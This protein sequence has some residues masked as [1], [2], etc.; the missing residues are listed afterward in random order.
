MS[1]NNEKLLNQSAFAKACGVVPSTIRNRVNRGVL[2]PA[3]S[4]SGK[5]YFTEEQVMATRLAILRESITQSFMGL[6]VVNDDA[7]YKKLEEDFV[8]KVKAV[9]PSVHSI[10]SL[11]ESMKAMGA[12]AKF[13][14]TAS[15]TPVFRG[16]VI[17][18]FISSVR[19]AVHSLISSV[20]LEE[21]LSRDYP[22]SFFV[23]VLCEDADHHPNAEM[24]EKYNSC[25]ITNMKYILSS[26]KS[27][28]VTRFDGLKRDYGVYMVCEN[29][30]FTLR[31]AYYTNGQVLLKDKADIIHDSMASGAQSI[32]ADIEREA[33]DSLVKGGVGVVCTEGFYTPIRISEGNSPA[34][35]EAVFNLLLSKDYKTVYLYNEDKLDKTILTL[36]TTLEQNGDITLV[37]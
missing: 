28:I 15:T 22:Y 31:D 10:T 37:R 20:Y 1:A 7:E 21:P 5:D 6:I 4:V 19:L 29:C 14:L 36:L 24:I 32:Y 12:G 35:Y 34:E 23:D 3:T 33:K 16:R 17:D 8:G 9:C 27:A 30:H 25:G 18:K 2:K 11:A 13:E 26:L